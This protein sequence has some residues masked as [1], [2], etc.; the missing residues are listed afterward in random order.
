MPDASHD[1]VSFAAA[2]AQTPLPRARED[3]VHQV[4]P[5]GAVLLSTR[6]EVYF[7]LNE[8]GA[9]VWQL[10]VAGGTLEHL[11]ERLAARYPEV[12]GVVLRA[13]VEELLADLAAARLVDP[14]PD[15]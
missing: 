10:V 9:E 8:V 3:V 15:A 12:E 13:D 11:C 1:V 6:D 14:T 4:V 7:G 2:S 5:E